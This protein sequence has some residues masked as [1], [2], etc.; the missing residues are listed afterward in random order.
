MG[1]HNII[2]YVKLWNLI[3]VRIRYHQLILF[4]VCGFYVIIWSTCI[5]LISPTFTS[6]DTNFKPIKT[7]DQ[8]L[9]LELDVVWHVFSFL[10][11]RSVLIL[12]YY[13]WL[14]ALFNYVDL[15]FTWKCELFPIILNN[16]MK[17]NRLYEITCFF[18]LF[19]LL[20]N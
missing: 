13:S 12:S 2:Y 1:F 11:V 9:L 6:N 7:K 18:F 14:H 20:Q 10:G 5:A 15:L 8:H 19:N 16:V 17:C 3:I 4:F